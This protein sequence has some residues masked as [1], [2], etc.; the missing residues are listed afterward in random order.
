MINPVVYPVPNDLSDFLKRCVEV[1]PN[2]VR[3]PSYRRLYGLR[4][5]LGA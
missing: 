5:Q 3:E 4:R 1:D 2:V